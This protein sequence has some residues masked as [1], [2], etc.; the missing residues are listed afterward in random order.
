MKE[1]GRLQIEGAQASGLHEAAAALQTV[2]SN[3]HVLLTG[4][5]ASV[6]PIIGQQNAPNVNVTVMLD[7]EEIV[8]PRFAA[9][10]EDQLSINEQSGKRKTLICLGDKKSWISKNTD[11]SCNPISMRQKK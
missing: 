1:A 2:A 6:Q 9:K 4:N 8:T 3:F 10:V 5:V 7:S 11:A